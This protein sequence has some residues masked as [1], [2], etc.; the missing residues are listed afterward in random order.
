[1]HE[2][3]SHTDTITNL[4]VLSSLDIGRHFQEIVDRDI[5]AVYAMGFFEQV[6]ADV[7]RTS[8]G[9]VEVMGGT[10]NEP[11]TNLT[12]PETTIRNLVHGI[13]FQRDVLGADPATAWQ[14]DVFG[15]D[16]QFPGMAADAGLIPGELAET[17]RAH[18]EGATT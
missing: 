12:S 5:R 2:S 6:T 11:N 18:L 15:H 3:R 13:G 9:R 4:V 1:M 17:V 16:P 14:L 10:Y 8:E 7:T